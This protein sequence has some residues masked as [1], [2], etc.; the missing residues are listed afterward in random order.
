MR[1]QKVMLDRDLAALYGVETKSLNKAV[2]RNLDRFPADFMFQLT[3]EEADGLRFQFGT[4]KRG[5]HS[6]YLPYAFTEQ[7]VAMLSSV[8]RSQQAVQVNVAIMR[9]F[10][11]LRETLSLHKERARKLAALEQKIEGHDTAIRSLFEAIRQLMAPPVPETKPEIG[12][13]IKEDAIPYRIRRKSRISGCTVT[14][15]KGKTYRRNDLRLELGAEEGEPFFVLHRKGKVLAFTVN[16]WQNPQA[17]AEILIGYGAGREKLAESF[18]ADPPIVPVFIK[19]QKEGTE[20]R[21]SGTFK[22]TG[23]CEEPLEKNRRVKPLDIPAIYKIL[24]LEEVR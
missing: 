5:Q 20:W 3:K 2:R 18:I 23:V 8:L 10:V 11:R 21:Y 17:P 1:G 7:G 16:H 4:L 15:E 6:K 24:F 12:F 14:F 22:L 13:H 19:E 9:A